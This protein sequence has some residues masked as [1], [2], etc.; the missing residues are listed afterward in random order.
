M[1]EPA[2]GVSGRNGGGGRGLSV[3][4]CGRKGYG[5]LSHALVNDH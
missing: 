1:I 3:V 2:T 5:E 4:Q